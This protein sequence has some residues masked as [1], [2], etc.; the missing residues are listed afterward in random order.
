[1]MPKPAMIKQ[2]I[3]ST[4]TGSLPSHP[5]EVIQI[6][7]RLFSQVP[8]PPPPPLKLRC[9]LVLRAVS[10]HPES[11]P[12]HTSSQAGNRVFKKIIIIVITKDKI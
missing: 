10:F 7:E 6:S 4:F 5:G 1:M 2:V 8:A 3:P 12:S 9:W 11:R